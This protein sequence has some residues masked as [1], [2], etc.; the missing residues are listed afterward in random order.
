[1]LLA[2]G[3]GINAGGSDNGKVR[4]MLDESM[5]LSTMNETVVEEITPVSSPVAASNIPSG[6]VLIRKSA[7]AFRYRPRVASMSH[8]QISPSN[9]HSHEKYFELTLEYGP[10][11]AGAAK[12]SESIPIVRMDT[13]LIGET[14]NSDVGK[15][16]SWEN[17]GRV[18]HSTQ[19]SAD[20]TDAYYMAP[21]SGVVFE[22]IIQRAVEY[23]YKRPRYQPFE[24]ISMPSGNLI[25]R[26]SGADD[27]V[28][29]MFHDLADLYVVIDPL[30]VPP[31]DKIQFYV[32]D[33]E[34]T[35]DG[36]QDGDRSESVFGGNAMRNDGKQVNPNVRKVKGPIEGQRAAVFYENLFNCVNA[37]KTGDYSLYVSP[38]SITPT[39]SPIASTAPSN[40]VTVV[41][42]SYSINDEIIGYNYSGAGS[43][44]EDDNGI[45]KTSDNNRALVN[46]SDDVNST[47]DERRILS[48]INGGPH[49][50]V[51]FLRY[52][53]LLDEI[54]S[55]EIVENLEYYDGVIEDN[56][57]VSISPLIESETMI[58]SNGTEGREYGPAE[59]PDDTAEAAS[60]TAGKLHR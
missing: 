4:K 16:V 55:D 27:F 46:P 31:R 59:Y 54:V 17:E 3:G 18:Y 50:S 11:R 25:L 2:S 15:Y 12:T 47:N 29:D 7:L 48:N 58:D 44:A 24:V 34:R 22:K 45:S 19:I 28:W 57:D 33:P 49:S 1:M 26:S 10:Q 36:L 43:D 51:K 42:D 56:N 60:E 37:I 8:G 53:R 32:A 41:E 40:A 35:A 38:P 14:S 39:L 13:D 23:T 52:P 5:E 20:W 30:L 9:Q 6:P 21:I